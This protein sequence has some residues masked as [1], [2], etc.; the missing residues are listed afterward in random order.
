MIERKENASKDWTQEIFASELESMELFGMEKKEDLD[1]L[2]LQ[3][4]LPVYRL[5][6]KFRVFHVPSVRE[7]LLDRQN[8][9]Q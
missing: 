7:W 9:G 3:Q 2:V 4:S 6:N 1:Y 8:S 5:K